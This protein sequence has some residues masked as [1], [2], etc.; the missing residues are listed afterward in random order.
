MYSMNWVQLS[1]QWIMYDMGYTLS[2]DWLKFD[3]SNSF[4]GPWL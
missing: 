1:D 3:V 4:S 2:G